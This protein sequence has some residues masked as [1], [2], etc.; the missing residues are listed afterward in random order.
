MM[1]TIE[2]RK[3]FIIFDL[4]VKRIKQFM[5]WKKNFKNLEVGNVITDGCYIYECK[6]PD[7]WVRSRV[8]LKF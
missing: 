7:K 3:Y 5:I 2:E 8:P 6:D 4:F 1:V